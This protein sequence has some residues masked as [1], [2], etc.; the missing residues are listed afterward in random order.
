MERLFTAG[1][2]GIAYGLAD[3][4][5]ALGVHGVGSK[6]I[7]MAGGAG[8]SALVQQLVADA[9]GLTVAV[10]ATAEPVLL[11]S[12][13]LGAVASGAFASLDQTMASMSSIG[14][15]TGPGAPGMRDFHHRKR[16]VYGL[17]REIDR[18]SRDAMRGFCIEGS[19]T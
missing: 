14:R 8:R 6:M 11:G 4:I 5:D 15:L 12:A 17:L 13:M 2:C 18:N 9:T 10:P 1:L 7:V 16:E 3:I 19:A